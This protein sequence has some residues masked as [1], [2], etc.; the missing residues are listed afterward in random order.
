MTELVSSVAEK[1]I[2]KLGSIAYQEICLAWGIESDLKNLELA[3]SAIQ[4]KLLDAEE[5][6]TKE[7]GLRV[8]LGQLKDVFYDAV[9]VL[10]EF[11]CEALRKQVVKTYGSTGKK[12]RRF[13][14]CSNPL[15]FRFK[16]G[17][18]MKEIRERL[19]GIKKLSDQYNLQ[20][21]QLDDK[22]IVV[23]ETHSFVPDSDVIGRDK[24]KEEIIDLLMQP[25]D[26]G[27][28]SV[29]PIVGLGGMGKTTLAQSVYNDEM[30]KR[31][32]FPRV[33]VCV[34]VD[35]DVKKLAKEILKSAARENSEKM[36]IDEN[37]SLD[38]VQ[39]SLRSVLKGKKFLIVLDDVWNEKRNKWNDLKTLLTGAK[40]S[41]II[42]TTRSKIVASVMAF[43]P[44]H[45][46]K[47]LSKDDCLRL[48]LRCAFKEGEDKDPKLVEF[49]DQIV[50]KCGGVPL[51]VKTLGSILYSKTDELEWIS[52]RDNEIWK[53]EQ[54]ENDILPA[55]RL[56]YNKLPLYLKHCFA[57]CSLYPKDYEYDSVELIQSWM[58]N[59]LL[60]KPDK[61][62]REL[63]DIGQQY[64]MELLARSF[65]QEARAWSSS[66][67]TH[68]LQDKDPNHFIFKIHDLLHDLSLYVARNDFCLIGNSNNT[69]NYDKA[70]YVSILNHNLGPNEVTTMLHKLK[71][72]VWTIILPSEF[73]HSINIKEFPLEICMSRFKYMRLLDLRRSTFEVLPSSIGTLKHLRYLDLRWNEH[74]KKFP[75]S[76]CELQN[77]ETLML[78][79]CKE[80]EEL[81]RDIRK[82]ISL[83]Y[84]LILTKQM[85]FPHNGIGCLRSLRTL[86]FHNCPKLEYFLDGIQHLTALRRLSFERCESLISLPSGMKDLNMLEILVISDCKKLT[87]MEGED[88][89]TSLRLLS[90]NKLPQQVAFPQGLKRSAST[91]QLL[92]IYHCHNLA[93][94]PEWL[95]DLSSLQ[96][97]EISRCTKLS[98]FPE[99]MHRLTA[100]KEVKID[101][102]HGSFMGKIPWPITEHRPIFNCWATGPP[103]GFYEKDGVLQQIIFPEDACCNEISLPTMT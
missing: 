49:G 29:I 84:L 5:R 74:I 28:V 20:E 87:L 53:L 39:A 89:P 19:E 1:V 61:S 10:D 64:A 100:L 46:L 71:N 40:G 54:E 47:G 78:D 33:W 12:V 73:G 79:G 32:F 15:A 31:D 65:F 88:Y 86:I 57:Y 52:V 50:K 44:I 11:E 30:V 6:Q 58:A 93:A 59:G 45:E 9:D 14:S 22:H 38:E 101:N 13:F 34:S 82:M 37:M 3:M 18:R 7:R 77:L 95:P 60:Q 66:Y 85:C 23:R 67:E 48:F 103:L 72:T 27:N 17:H 69:N 4:A 97:L 76:I 99:G 96:I 43:G 62:T 51:A 63:E 68:S 16:M 90:I 36:H 35:F 2:E 80:L 83:R 24:D 25:G 70:R 42:V 8:W 81:P 56:S 41:K 21:R 94:L 98:S 55:L 92:A 75:N 91:L 102:C 26:D